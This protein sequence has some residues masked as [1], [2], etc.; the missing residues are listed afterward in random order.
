MSYWQAIANITFVEKPGPD[1][2]DVT[3][4]KSDIS[5]SGIGYPAYVGE[6]C[7]E[8]A[9]FLVLGSNYSYYNYKFSLALH[10]IGH[11]L[12]LGHVTSENVMNPNRTFQQLQPGDIAGIQS[13]YGLK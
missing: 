12:G 13:I 1:K 10:E 3:I 9:G 6:P 11:V 2:T 4:I 5:Q 7:S 8:I